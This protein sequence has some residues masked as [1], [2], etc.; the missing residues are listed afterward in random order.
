MQHAQLDLSDSVQVSANQTKTTSSSKQTKRP[1][2]IEVVDQR[3]EGNLEVTTVKEDVDAAPS[4]DALWALV[5]HQRFEKPHCD[6]GWTC[7]LFTSKG[8]RPIGR[9]PGIVTPSRVS[10]PGFRDLGCLGTLGGAY[11]ERHASISSACRAAEAGKDADLGV[12]GVA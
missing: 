6:Y 4:V 1:K 5:D 3:R 2:H 12:F 9:V 11:V 8:P 7:S 10:A